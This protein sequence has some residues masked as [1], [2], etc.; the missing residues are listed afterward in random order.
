MSTS[1]NIHQ[2]LAQLKE[3]SGLDHTGMLSELSPQDRRPTGNYE[4]FQKQ[5]LEEYKN[6]LWDF[7]S[8]NQ[9]EANTNYSSLTRRNPGINTYE[10]ILNKLNKICELPSML[11]SFI[12]T[13]TVE[14]AQQI[15]ETCKSILY[16]HETDT[17]APLFQTSKYRD[18]TGNE[19]KPKYGIWTYNEKKYQMKT[20]IT[21]VQAIMMFFIQKLS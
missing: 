21:D 19:L 16:G 11:T 6:A 10:M 8:I 14:K 20:V 1:R 17:Y 9:E 13:N 4:E 5:Q 15:N 7:M 2:S 12:A 3:L 18:N